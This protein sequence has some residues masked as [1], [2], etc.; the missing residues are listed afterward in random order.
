[1]ENV[2]IYGLI[3][4]INNELRYIGKSINPNSRYRKHLQDSKKKIT[5]KDKWIFNL[6]NKNVKPELIIIDVVTN[7][8]WVFWEI[9]YISYY[10][11]IGW[12][13]SNL[14]TGWDNPPNHKGRKRTDEEIK[15]ISESHKGI[16]K[17]DY[18]RKKMS[19]AKKGKPILHLN[20][21]KPR[22]EEHKKNLSLS[23]K[24]RISTNKGN[25]YSKELKQKL[26]DASTCKKKVN[27]FTKNGEFIKCWNSIID[28][29]KCLNIG[30]I[31]EC[32]LHKYKSAGGYRWEYT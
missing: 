11:S 15:K 30:H 6:I 10:R 23:L 9:H 22:T 18:V 28:A 1:M 19:D 20:N 2:Y 12:R 25:K 16:K 31:S 32:C 3:D 4:P 17:T 21:G 5:Y 24:G 8:N 27:Q 13:L 26:S 7:D 29:K 14:T